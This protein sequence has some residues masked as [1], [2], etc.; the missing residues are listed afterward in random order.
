MG[1]PDGHIYLA[2]YY[3]GGSA[4]TGSTAY[5]DGNWHHAV[6]VFDQSANKLKLYMD[7]ALNLA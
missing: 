4:I 7:G 6:V 3:L 1:N 2:N 5:D